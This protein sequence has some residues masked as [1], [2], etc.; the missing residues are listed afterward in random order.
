MNLPNKLTVSRMIITPVF[1]A[2]M[3]LSSVPFNYSAALI[4]FVVGSLTDL[5]DGKIARKNG[6]VTNFGK[7]LDPVADKML[8]TAALLG[9]MV[10]LPGDGLKL[11]MTIITFLTLFREF[12]VASVRLI[13]VSSETKKVIAANIWGKIKTVFQML[14]IILGLSAYSVMEFV[15][16]G[17]KI[18][19][20]VMIV[21]I[22][23]SWIAAI[24]GV[25]SG[26]I[27]ITES[28]ELIDSSK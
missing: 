8:T 21:F 26:I 9:F 25:I 5:L 15:P 18:F 1:M 17:E 20:A 6:I 7:F 4:L 19:G 14:S 10:I 13:A 27:Y 3:L 16:L 28:R 2:A 24:T 22:L 11:Q 23:L 12:A